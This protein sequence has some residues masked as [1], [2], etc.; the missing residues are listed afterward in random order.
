MTRTFLTRSSLCN[1]ALFAALSLTSAVAAGCGDP[2]VTAQD[3]G[4]VV[5]G[6]HGSALADAPPSGTLSAGVLFMRLVG[7]PSDSAGGGGGGGGSGEPPRGR[8]FELETEIV[9]GQISGSLPA[10]FSVELAAPER[11]YSFDTNIRYLNL[12]GTYA[13]GVFSTDHAPDGVRIGHLVIG[14]ASEL[15]ALPRKI[16]VD[17]GNS[18]GVGA[19]LRPYL[20]NTTISSYQI[21]FAEGV[22]A[23]DVI[24]P[25]TSSSGE[26]SGGIA[27]SNGY[28]LVDARTYLGAV[29]WQ[30]C[31]NDNLDVRDRP[32]YAACLAAN[33]GRISCDQAC[34]PSSRDALLACQQACAEQYPGQLNDSGCLWQVA[35][36]DVDRLCGAEKVPN[37]SQLRLV[38]EN[39][40]LS[41]KLG[42][43]DIKNG[44]WFLHVTSQP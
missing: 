42:D 1:P 24:Y 13:D 8:T 17:L 3:R 20:A 29:Q 14:P 36:P 37:P 30:E 19:T 39:E 7:K 26:V 25:T 12:D 40:S 43:D 31:A 9:L 32:E 6:L 21:I 2:L 4:D 28:T 34:D 10:D 41:V 11:T 5:L 18:R 27:I 15:A 35:Q 44:L 38:D 23:G 33:T 16:P 22:G